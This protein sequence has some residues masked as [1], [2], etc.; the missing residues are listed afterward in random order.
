MND[1]KVTEKVRSWETHSRD[2]VTERVTRSHSASDSF[3]TN[4]LKLIENEID[5]NRKKEAT[6]V[7]ILAWNPGG[8][9]R[10]KSKMETGFSDVR[11]ISPSVPS[12]FAVALLPSG[13]WF[14][15]FSWTSISVA[16]FNLGAIAHIATARR[17]SR[18]GNS[19]QWNVR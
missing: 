3:S 11:C 15:K 6:Y 7:G 16:I 5:K 17:Q 2:S 10:S 4:K 1:K 14:S 18:V 12:P 9:F 19:F 8:G 13:L